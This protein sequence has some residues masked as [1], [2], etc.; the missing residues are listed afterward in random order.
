VRDVFDRRP[1]AR[2]A[3]DL[4]IA[5]RDVAI[6]TRASLLDL[7]E[8]PRGKRSGII[9]DEDTTPDQIAT[10]RHRLDLNNTAA[11]PVAIELPAR[12]RLAKH[13]FAEVNA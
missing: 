2:N 5:L 8:Q 1:E 9:G 4:Q 13:S 11:D 12:R 3:A 6:I 7:G 10:A